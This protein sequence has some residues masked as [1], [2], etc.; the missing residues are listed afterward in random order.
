MT[1]FI[2]TRGETEA[3]DFVK[4]A[5]GGYAD[6]GG[7]YLPKTIP[8][9]SNATLQAW[10]KLSYPQLCA[11]ILSLFIPPSEVSPQELNQI[12][13]TCFSTFRHPDIAPVHSLSPESLH[14]LE[15]FHG[16]TFA[17]KDLGLQFIGSLFEL[18]LQKKQKQSKMNILVATSGDTG[19]SAIECVKGKTNVNIFVLFP[20][21]GRISELQERQMTTVLD[22]NVCTVEV[23][24]TSDDAD[25]PIRELFANEEDRANFSLC[26]INS[27]NICRLLMQ[28]VH[29]FFAYFQLCPTCNRKIRFYIPCGG[30]GNCTS[31]RIAQQMNLPIEKLVVAVNDN[32]SLYSLFSSGHVAVSESVVKTTSPS[33]DI[34]IPYNLERFLYLLTNGDA[35]SVKHWMGQLFHTGELQLEDS[36]LQEIKTSILT[37]SASVD[38]VNEAIQTCY[39]NYQYVLDPHTACAYAAYLHHCKVL[40]CHH[41]HQIR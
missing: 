12:L 39:E 14:V 6:D 7:M 19:A 24:G 13:Q 38:A 25:V 18:L 31:A 5:L 9:V 17:F 33:M 1:C 11:E 28:V 30:F 23:E 21:Q 32:D 3:V 35:S 22:E 37:Y 40:P 15:L 26:S 2:S 20:G 4:A 36:L 41:T 27:V 34:Q 16:P 8:K 29:Y 10:A